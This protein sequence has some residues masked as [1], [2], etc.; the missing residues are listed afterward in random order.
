MIFYANFHTNHLQ[1]PSGARLLRAIPNSVRI[2]LPDS[3]HAALLE[4]GVDLSKLIRQVVN[5]EQ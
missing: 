4:S 2:I 1:P 3:G 5:S